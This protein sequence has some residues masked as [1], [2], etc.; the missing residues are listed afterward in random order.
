MTGEEIIEALV[1]NSVS[2]KETFDALMKKYLRLQETFEDVLVEQFAAAELRDYWRQKAGYSLDLRDMVSGSQRGF[3]EKNPN[4]LKLDNN[5]EPMNEI[6]IL[7]KQQLEDLALQNENYGIEFCLNKGNRDAS[8]NGKP[9]L[10]EPVAIPSEEDVVAARQNKNYSAGYKDA[11]FED[12]VEWAFN[13][14]KINLP[15]N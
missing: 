12:G 4:H 15:W 7:T 1:Q 5:I 3:L 9:K 8:V 13:W 6:Y 2:Q 10:T 14:L 11:A